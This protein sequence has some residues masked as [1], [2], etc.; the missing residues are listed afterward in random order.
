VVKYPLIH[1]GVA[2]H[3]YVWVPALL[4]T[5]YGLGTTATAFVLPDYLTRVQGLRALQIGDV[6]NWIALPQFLLVPL[7]AWLLRW[8]D[9]R[10]MIAIGFAIIAVGSWM[11]A[12]LT[13]DWANAD[14][15]PSQIVQA[16]GLAL[17]ITALVTYTVA[18]ITPPQAAAIAATIQTARLFGSELGSAFI[19][20]FVRIRE[21][22]H[23]NLIEQHLSSGTD[24]VQR[25][26]DILS[27]VFDD[28]PTGRD[29]TAQALATIGARVQRQSF[30]LAYID[31]FWVIA[32]GLTFAILLL[33]LLRP[34]PP[35]PLTPP[36]KSAG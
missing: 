14:F 16:V 26:I 13:H 35:N 31:A 9:A 2:S 10:L 15:L 30:V 21:Q 19:Q 33:L 17:A 11:D 27:A 6:L 4:I 36:L 5:V 28:H 3:R 23:S 25:F 12:D 8:I 24:I 1:L 20:T 34:P 32:W 29:A 22:F 18:N 7:I